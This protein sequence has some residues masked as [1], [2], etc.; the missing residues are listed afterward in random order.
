MFN[1]LLCSDGWSLKL[2]YVKGS[3]DGCIGVVQRRNPIVGT[4]VVGNIVPVPTLCE[5]P[6][7]SPKMEKKGRKDEC[8]EMLTAL[9]TL[10]GVCVC[11]CV[12]GCVCV[13]VC[14]C[15]CSIVYM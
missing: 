11:V 7:L 8:G 13:C 12:C 2:T 14:V 10:D 1:D 3:I 6:S 9:C 4:E 5:Q 15:H